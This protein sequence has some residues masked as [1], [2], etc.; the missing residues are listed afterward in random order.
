MLDVRLWD[1]ASEIEGSVGT[2]LSEWQPGSLRRGSPRLQQGG[3]QS[4]SRDWLLSQRMRTPDSQ[5]H[6][7]GLSLPVTVRERL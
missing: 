4:A 7:A 1:F 3:Q 6:V 5:Q 2:E